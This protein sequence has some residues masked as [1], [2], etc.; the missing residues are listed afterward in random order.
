MLEKNDPKKESIVGAVIAS[1]C[2]IVY[3]V[4]LVFAF[5]RIYTNIDQ[6][7]ITAAREFSDMA[8]L[9]SSAGVLGF[10]DEPFI[11]TMNDALAKSGTLE[12]V[13][14]SGSNGEYAFE[15]ERGKTVNWVNNSPRFKNRFDLSSQPLYQPLRI[16]GMRNVNIQAAAGAV[17]FRAVSGILQQTLLMILLALGLS[18]F[19]L[20]LESLVGKNGKAAVRRRA[21]YRPAGVQTTDIPA[22]DFE[23]LEDTEESFDVPPP[24]H[25]RPEPER[26]AA[27]PR[28]AEIPP[29]GQS[30]RGIHSPSGNIGREDQT[31][32]RL[33]SELLR[34]ASFG[35]DLTFIAAEIK[36]ACFQGESFYKQFAE[37]AVCF[38]NQRD[39]VF[40]RGER[41]IAVIYPNIDLESAF[42]KYGEFHLRVT[43]KYSDIFKSKNDICAGLSS[44]SGRIID[45]KRL[46]FEADEAL[47]RA[48]EDPV[49]HIVAFKSDPDKYRAFLRKRG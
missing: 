38:F 20:V 7:R 30:P 39:L 34:C 2:I 46:M 21:E 1:F 42:A 40:E 8:D 44:R 45:A 10:M 27:P 48:L 28:A 5:V 47:G 43:E 13:I 12:A 32:I 16:T 4:A 15:R 33:E 31:A 14:I 9:A 22:E 25:P 11:E 37:E 17:D 35:Q 24:A 23:D 3:L 6:R 41:G 36:R 26:E 29:A 49:S 18:F 19:T